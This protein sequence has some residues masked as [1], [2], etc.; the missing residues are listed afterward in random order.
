[1]LAGC[2]LCNQLVFDDDHMAGYRF[3]GVAPLQGLQEPLWLAVCLLPRPRLWCSSSLAPLQ[4]RLGISSAAVRKLELLDDFI[5][6]CEL[7]SRAVA[8]YQPPDMVGSGRTIPEVED[9]EGAD[10]AERGERPPTVL[11]GQSGGHRRRTSSMELGDPGGEHSRTGRARRVIARCRDHCGF[12]SSVVG[13]R[14][15]S[16]RLPHV[17]ASV[18]VCYLV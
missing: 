14:I 4:K 2:F 16:C 3:C 7:L 18:G 10:A 13:A 17:I 1:M 15:S 5:V 8:G 6:L 12:L 11:Q 9:E